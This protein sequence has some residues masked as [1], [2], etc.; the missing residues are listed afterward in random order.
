VGYAPQQP[1]PYSH[2]LHAGVNQIPCEFCHAGAREGR[3]AMIPA[4]EACFKCHKLT[5]P[6][7]PLIKQLKLALDS[8]Q[9][10]P[11]KRVH[12]L[13]DHVYFD[14]RPHVALGIACQE[15]HGPVE[16]MDVVSQV[17]SLRMGACLQCHRGERRWSTPIPASRPD[18]V[19]V[20]S[21]QPTGPTSCNAC[22]R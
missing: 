20:A 8:G 22:H 12:D 10:W 11:W 18:M 6:D 3:H 2:R 17:T 19:Q 13:P 16:T 9:P 15:C 4:V 1:I 7:S 21:G 14:H 5:L